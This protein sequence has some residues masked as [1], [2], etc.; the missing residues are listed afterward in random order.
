[1]ID[2]HCHIL[3]GLDDGAQTLED[4]LEMARVAAKDGIHTIAATPHADLWG[5]NPDQKDLEER[6]AQLQ[7]AL[8]PQCIAI[9]LVPGMENP[10]TP[11]LVSGRVVPLNHTGYALVELPF[12]EFP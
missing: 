12:E 2:L 11:E 9:T 6:V 5:T 10:L 4:S 7:A 1:M 8:D 3:P